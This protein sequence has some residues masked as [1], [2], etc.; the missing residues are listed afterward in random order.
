MNQKSVSAAG[1]ILVD[2]KLVHKYRKENVLISNMRRTLPFTISCDVFENEIR[3]KC[4]EK[5]KKTV[6]EC[7]IKVE[8]NNSF[9]YILRGVKQSY[10]VH[11]VKK[12]LAAKNIS[13]EDIRFF[14]RLYKRD[15]AKSGYYLKNKMDDVEVSRIARIM[16]TKKHLLS[17]QLKTKTSEI[18]ER[19]GI[20]G[21]ASV[22]YAN[23]VID[24][25]HYYFFE[26]PNEHVPGMMLIEA[27]RQLL[28]ACTHQFGNVPLSGYNFVLSTMTGAF[29]NYLELNYPVLFKVVQTDLHAYDTGIWADSDFKVHVYQAEKEA[30]II[31]F[32]EN[33]IT[34]RV[35]KRLRSSQESVARKSWFVL[36]TNIEY[37]A[38]IRGE[39][40]KKIV[41]RLEYISQEDCIFLADTSLEKIQKETELGTVEFFMYFSNIGF[42]HGMGNVKSENRFGDFSQVHIRFT[43]MD[44]EDKV[45][46]QEVIRKY[47]YLVED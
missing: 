8:N 23:M 33:I 14:L 1:G 43:E 44:K 17:D 42:V 16:G 10:P 39:G 4:N 31:T 45:N 40:I 22:F 35:F 47:A 6:D 20:V 19:F 32:Q 13:K 34:N 5:E 28:V 9:I 7:Y 41:V 37:S 18:L 46:L 36:K 27:V 26:H 2:Q 21:D 24:T 12:Y 3:A 29:K 25:G 11:E 15:S 30:A 38:V